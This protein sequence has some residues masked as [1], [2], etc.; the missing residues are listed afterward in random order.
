MYKKKLTK[1][2]RVTSGRNNQGKITVRHK[3][4][5]A[6]KRSRL[7]CYTTDTKHFQ[8]ISELKNT[9][10]NNKLILILE[11]NTTIKFRIA[12][13][14]LDNTKTTF[15]FDKKAISLG[16]DLFLRDVPLGSEIHAIRDSKNENPIYL[17]SSGTYGKLL[18]KENGK[19][20]IRLRS[21][22]I[23]IFPEN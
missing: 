10:S 20:F 2:T 21:K 11:N 9:K 1:F 16:S 13:Q 17:R 3:E 23:K 15:C 4:G 22:F 12:T 19:V 8:V 6:K 7:F 14:G 18:K 5:G